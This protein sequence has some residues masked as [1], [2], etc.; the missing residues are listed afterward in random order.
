MAWRP[1]SKVR[2]DPRQSLAAGCC[3]RC[4]FLYQHR[5]LNWQFQFT[6][7][8][9]TN[10]RILVCRRCLDRPS[11]FLRSPIL[12]PDPVAIMNAR[13]EPF[14]YDGVSPEETQV[15]FAASLN[16]LIVTEDG[17][18]MTPEGTNVVRFP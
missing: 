9:L 3:D 7:V 1:H 4:G 17:K 5:D 16:S 18:L 11:E 6:G 13:P 14:A 10:L 15:M 12:S 8:R 2:V